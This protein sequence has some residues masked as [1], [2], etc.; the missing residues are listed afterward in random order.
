MT[1]SPDTFCTADKQ[2][3]ADVYAPSPFKIHPAALQWHSMDTPEVNA[4]PQDTI[5]LLAERAKELAKQW[6][7]EEGCKLH[8]FRGAYLVGS[9]TTL[10]DGAAVPATSD[11]DIV[12]ALE[13]AAATKLGKFIYRDLLLDV[14]CVEWDQIQSHGSIL[15][16]FQMAAA[17][18]DLQILADPSGH[19]ARI[20]NIVAMNYAS[21]YWVRQRIHHAGDRV[22]G[23]LQGVGE[24]AA[25]HDQV[26][27]WLFGT[28][29]TTLMLTTSGLRA[30]TVRRRYVAAR[31]LLAAHGKQEFYESLLQLL[32]CADWSKS[33]TEEHLIAVA[34]AFDDAKRLPKGRFKFA[35]DI[36]DTARPIALDGSRD[37]IEQGLHREAVYWMVATYARCQWIF[38]HSASAS[39]REQFDPGFQ[40]ILGDLGIYS[41]ADLKGRSDRVRSFLPRVSG[42]ADAIMAATPGIQD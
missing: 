4:R 9:V 19:L 41:F 6:V 39:L 29:L 15:G 7:R 10:A 31:E 18:R 1:N 11:V 28:S 33:Q 27:S 26:T 22:L 40:R 35:A 20:R 21:R 24:S 42:T 8:G 36:S 38:N 34:A 25:W 13:R 16:H 3:A 32:G 30:P 2:L 5:P 17:F 23:Y 37:L 12:V 14:S